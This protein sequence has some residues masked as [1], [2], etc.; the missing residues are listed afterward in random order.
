MVLENRLWL[1]FS[2]DTDW[3][4]GASRGQIHSIM[5]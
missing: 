1:S 5:F 2:G 4:G 3:E